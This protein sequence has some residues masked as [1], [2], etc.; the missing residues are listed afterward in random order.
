MK[1]TD[2]YTLYIDDCINALVGF[3]SESVH[4]IYLDP[5][6]YTQRTHRLVTRDRRSQYSF[7][8]IWASES[9]Y[10][11]FLES[12]LSELI[13]VLRNDGA[14]FFHCDRNASHIIR[15]LLDRLLGATM[16]RS[17]IIWSYRRWSI[18][19]DSLVPAHQTILYYTKSE[20]YTFN[21]IRES[22]SPTT[23]VDQ[24]MQQRSRDGFGK[25]VYK[26]GQEGGI[27]G[28]GLKARCPSK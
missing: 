16:F 18:S 9:E 12:R 26:R 3:P 6:F 2:D 19:R 15:M 8:D 23:N 27:S 1:S 14:L 24:I 7:D 22:Y 28:N 5:P 13:R 4:C 17:E 25:T 11:L 21:I 10:C 20:H